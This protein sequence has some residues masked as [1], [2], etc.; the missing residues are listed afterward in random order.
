MLRGLRADKVKLV[1]LSNNPE[2]SDG[3]LE[4]KLKEMLEAAA[5]KVRG[6]VGGRVEG[7]LCWRGRSITD[8]HLD[9]RYT[10]GEGGLDGLEQE[11]GRK[12]DWK[13]HKGRSRRGGG[14]SWR[15]KGVETIQEKMEA[16]LSDE[17]SKK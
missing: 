9:I 3:A 16:A 8:A 1:I 2:E 15:R 14:F 6:L 17:I 7:L 10:T 5:E 12:E 4:D 11:A 13:E